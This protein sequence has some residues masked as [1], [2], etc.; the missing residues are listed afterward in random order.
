M[1]LFKKIFY[2]QISMV[3][4][5]DMVVVKTIYFNIIINFVPEEWIDR[6][7]MNSQ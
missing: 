1:V 4:G 6:L 3:V 2:V 5:E 7:D